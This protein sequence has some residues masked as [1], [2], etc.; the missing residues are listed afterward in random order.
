MVHRINPSEEGS[1]CP[2]CFGELSPLM[3]DSLP[4]SEEVR[5]FL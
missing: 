2:E 1:V 5:R 3:T 4:P